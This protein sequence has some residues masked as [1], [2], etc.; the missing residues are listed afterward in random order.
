MRF[1][2]SVSGGR[3]GRDDYV[4]GQVGVGHCGVGVRVSSEEVGLG[5]SCEVRVSLFAWCGFALGQ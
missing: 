4:V 1:W 2:M 5:L 3:G